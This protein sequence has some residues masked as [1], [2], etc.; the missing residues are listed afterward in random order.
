MTNNADK[1]VLSPAL[2]AVVFI[3]AAAALQVLLWKALPNQGM[4]ALALFYVIWPLNALWAI[5]LFFTL[6]KEKPLKVFLLFVN[7]LLMIAVNVWV[8][9]Q[10]EQ[11]SFAEKLDRLTS[12]LH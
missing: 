7:L 11:I 3:A 10:E 5:I 1:S 6:P 4:G 12:I 9:P 8:Y 2:L